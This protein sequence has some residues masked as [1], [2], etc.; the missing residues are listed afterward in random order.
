MLKHHPDP[1]AFSATHT[2]AGCK[3][4]GCYA[5]VWRRKQSQQM[6]LCSEGRQGRRKR[7][8]NR[9]RERERESCVCGDTS[10]WLDKDWGNLDKNFVAKN[11]LLVYVWIC[12]MIMISQQPSLKYSLV[13]A[14]LWTRPTKCSM[15]ASKRKTAK[16]KKKKNDQSDQ[17]AYWHLPAIRIHMAF[18]SY[19]VHS[20]WKLSIQSNRMYTAK[21]ANC[22]GKVKS[23]FL[24]ILALIILDVD[25]VKTKSSDFISVQLQQQSGPALSENKVRFSFSFGLLH[26]TSVL[27][28]PP[29]VS[30]LQRYYQGE[31]SVGC[32][33]KTCWKS[34]VQQNQSSR[35]S[36]SDRATLRS[37]VSAI[38]VLKVWCSASTLFPPPASRPWGSTDDY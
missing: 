14:I 25:K 11:M 12:L 33:T 10:I 29:G 17:S 5:D 1:V 15:S 20:S 18:S 36:H 21:S 31:K 34:V 16:K 24:R 8:R 3:P 7:V 35:I 37:N 2:F 32:M 4:T 13:K 23:D 27:T 26:K 30:S 19:L 28:R 38:T 22:T 9:E 6:A